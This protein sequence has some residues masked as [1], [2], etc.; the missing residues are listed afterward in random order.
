MKN[1]RK[2]PSR[3]ASLLFWVRVAAAATFLQF[4]L[5]S[6]DCLH[7]VYILQCM[8]WRTAAN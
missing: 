8:W 5:T 1:S 2:R 4:G 6:P 3:R 7:M